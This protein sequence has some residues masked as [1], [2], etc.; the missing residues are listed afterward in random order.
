MGIVVFFL[1]LLTVSV[2]I[3]PYLVSKTITRNVIKIAL[4]LFVVDK[5]NQY[6]FYCLTDV[7]Y[8]ICYSGNI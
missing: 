8:C 3:V 2:L 6:I 4:Y 5:H 7:L 1:D